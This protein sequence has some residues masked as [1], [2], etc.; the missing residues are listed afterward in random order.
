MQTAMAVAEQQMRPGLPL[1]TPPKIAELIEHCWNQDPSKR[2]EFS[3]IVQVLP[4]V[5]QALSKADFKNAGILY[6]V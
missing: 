3:A 6:T 2:P 5:K 1:K 4:Y